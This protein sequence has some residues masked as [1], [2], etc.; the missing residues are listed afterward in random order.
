MV[1]EADFMNTR[2]YFLI[3]ICPTN[4]GEYDEWSALA[5]LYCDN[6]TGKNYI[7]T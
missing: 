3:Q 4:I 5:P 2:E 1:E 6:F 7:G